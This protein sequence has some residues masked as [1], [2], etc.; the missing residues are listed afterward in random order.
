ME[1]GLTFE[2]R[3]VQLATVAEVEAFVQEHPTS[4]IFKAGAC[5]QTPRAL[6]SIRPVLDAYGALPLAVITVVA[7]RAASNRLAELTGIRHA[8]PQLLL[9][10]DGGAVWA[11]DSWELT[12]EATRESFAR[13]LKLA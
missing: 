12:E 4:A 6:D 2:E 11:A 10:K 8:S 1:Q 5:G 9:L 7:A 13:H 3:A